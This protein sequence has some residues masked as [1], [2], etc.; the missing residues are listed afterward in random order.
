MAIT[1]YAECAITCDARAVA[2]GFV[3]VADAPTA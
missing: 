2:R 1:L 3:I